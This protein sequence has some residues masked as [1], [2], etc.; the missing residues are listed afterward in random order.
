VEQLQPVASNKNGNSGGSQP[1][2]LQ[3]HTFCQLTEA[4]LAAGSGCG[5]FDAIMVL[6]GGLARDG[7]LPE[8]VHRCVRV[9]WCTCSAHA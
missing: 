3:Q 1:H 9:V 4:D 5:P 6:A 8:W 7:G 2:Q